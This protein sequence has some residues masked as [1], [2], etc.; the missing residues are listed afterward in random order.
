MKRVALLGLVV[1]G[2]SAP[3]PP[4]LGQGDAGA[5]TDASDLVYDDS[6]PDGADASDGANEADAAEDDGGGPIPDATAACNPAKTWAA[7]SP[8]ALTTGAAAL[9]S[10][11]GAETTIAW[12][13][14]S[15]DVIHWA[16][17]DDTTSPWGAPQSITGGFALGERV[18]LTSNGLAIYAVGTDHRSLVAF[19]RAQIGDAFA[20]TSDPVL[21][22]VN[23]E[24]PSGTNVSDVVLS[25]SSTMLLLRWVGGGNDGLRMARRVMP[26]D[27]WPT[28]NPFAVQPETQMVG[29]KARRPTGISVDGRALFYW[30][31]TTDVE[32]IGFFA[33]DAT[34]MNQFTNLG[35][36]PDA[37]VNTDCS[38]LYFDDGAGTLESA[39]H[40]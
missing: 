32:M 6:G 2:C 38:T 1:L 34:T 31:E 26:T 29:G 30:D 25:P 14:T 20:A 15:D 28:S 24:V 19:E 33:W 13:T 22:A 40:P 36:R 16:D 21:D 18:A 39:Q 4:P 11:D 12:V 10:I 5:G 37:Q 17:R 35:A 8:L 9:A 23:A 7:G 3:A 27:V